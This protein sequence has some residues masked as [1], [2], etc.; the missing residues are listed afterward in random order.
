[1]ALKRQEAKEIYKQFRQLSEK[2][3]PVI[4]DN[5]EIKASSVFRTQLMTPHANSSQNL[6]LPD[7]LA[8]LKPD[9][10]QVVAKEPRGNI[11]DI[12]PADHSKNS[13]LQQLLS[14]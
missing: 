4:P 7:D 14:E 9:Q 12:K 8:R 5:P 6:P 10:V 2:N 13:L 11:E 1:M 3:E